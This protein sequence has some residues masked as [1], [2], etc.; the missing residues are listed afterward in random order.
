MQI[1]ADF[2]QGDLQSV[3]TSFTCGLYV[4]VVLSLS[5]TNFSPSPLTLSSSGNI[6]ASSAYTKVII[7]TNENRIA[8]I[9]LFFI[10]IFFNII[11]AIEYKIILVYNGQLF[12]Y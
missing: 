7:K 2:E 1:S 8:L 4:I 10:V 3:S 11:Y 5:T 6:A 12:S 9:G